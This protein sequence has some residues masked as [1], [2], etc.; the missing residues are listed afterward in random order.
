[1]N[2]PSHKRFGVIA[3]EKGFLSKAQLVEALEI[4]TE[5]NVSLGKHRLIGQILLDKGYITEAQ[6]EEVLKVINDQ[7]VYMLS[8]GR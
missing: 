8:V 7:M 2:N 6:I 3:I 1:M 5:E 4:Q